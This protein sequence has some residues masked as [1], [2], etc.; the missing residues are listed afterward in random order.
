MLLKSE[1]GQALVEFTLV[2]PILLLLVFGVVEFGRIYS[3]SLAVNHVARETARAAVV[4][5]NGTDLT[6]VIKNAAPQLNYNQLNVTIAPA[7]LVRGEEVT[8]DVEYTVNIQAPF[9]NLII[10][11]PFLV[12]GTIVMRVE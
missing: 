11:D 2:L 3:A 10:P 12:R 9:I 4:G 7:T 8:V 6:N 1:K 5:T